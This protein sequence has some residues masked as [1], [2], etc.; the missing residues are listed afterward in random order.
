MARLFTLVVLTTCFLNSGSLRA[1]TKPEG[2]ADEKGKSTPALTKLPVPAPPS[3]GIAATQTAPAVT[4]KTAQPLPL[5]ANASTT[6]TGTYLV[7]NVD[8]FS[9]IYERLVTNLRYPR[10]SGHVVAVARLVNCLFNNSAVEKADYLDQVILNLGVG[11]EDNIRRRLVAAETQRVGGNIRYSAQA[12]HLAAVLLCKLG[13]RKYE[14]LSADFDAALLELTAKMA[15]P[16]GP[17]PLFPFFQLISVAELM[18]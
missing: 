12:A 18:N 9:V 2:T 11:T 1:Q 5:G 7:S 15:K 13:T 17:A 10:A 3:P 6:A 16:A 8:E 4:T 14:N